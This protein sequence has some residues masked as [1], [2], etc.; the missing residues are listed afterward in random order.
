MNEG[1]KFRGIKYGGIKSKLIKIKG[2]RFTLEMTL[3][4]GKNR[5]I[6]NIAKYFK[7]N[8]LNL[9]RIQ[10]GDYT[11]SKL[12]PSDLK[13]ERLTPKIINHIEKIY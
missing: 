2:Q 6:R 1:I 11:L 12:K 3:L 8:V 13:E 10:H 7:W 4:E 9:K 5:E